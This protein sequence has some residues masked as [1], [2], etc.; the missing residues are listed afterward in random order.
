MCQVVEHEQV[1]NRGV[2]SQNS[3]REISFLY[4]LY[5]IGVF[6]AQWLVIA[7][8]GVSRVKT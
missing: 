2:K 8:R 3:Q 6:G 1:W 7:S 4:V 5:N